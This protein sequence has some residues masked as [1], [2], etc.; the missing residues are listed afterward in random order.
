MPVYTNSSFKPPFYFKNNHLQT[1]YPALLRRVNGVIYQRQRVEM[2]DGDFI[3]LDWSKVGSKKLLIALHGLEGNADRPYIK[4]SIRLFNLN[5]WDGLGINLR[6][7]S[8]VPNR[9]LYAYHTGETND[10][11]SILKTILKEGHYDEIAL[12]GFSLGGNVILKYLGEEG[13]NLRDKITKA[14]AFSVPCDLT[15]ASLE[16]ARWHNALYMKK[17]YG[18]LK[19]KD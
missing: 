1:I 6:G 2:N 18:F 12:L 17:I 10:L 16:L 19:T 9:K 15:T 14:V 11:R 8:G 3:D 13:E 5:G 4:A 7:C